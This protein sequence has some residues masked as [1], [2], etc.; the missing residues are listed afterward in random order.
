MANLEIIIDGDGHIFE[1]MVELR[2]HLP[3][4][5]NKTNVTQTLS[6]FPQIDHIHHGLGMNPPDTFGIGSDGVFRNPGV[7]GWHEFMEKAGIE[8]TVVYPTAA[9]GYGRMTDVDYAILACRAYNDWLAEAYVQN[10]SRFNGVA[11][12]PMQ[13][14]QAAVEE[15][16]RAVNDL[17]MVGAMLPST[18]LKSPLGD[19]EYW[20]VYAEAERLGCAMAIHGGAHQDLGMNTMNKVGPIHAI[21]HPT[22][23]I[24][25]FGSMI[26]NG[27]FDR[28]PTLK[29]GF[30]EAGVSWLLVAL[31][32]FSGSYHAVEPFPPSNGFPYRPHMDLHAGE[33]AA[34]YVKRLIKQ[35]NIFIGVEGDELT[36]AFAVKEVGPEPFIYSSDFPHEVNIHTVRDEIQELL[37]NEELTAEEKEGILHKNSQK[38]YG[39]TPVAAV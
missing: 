36:L 12:L 26:F 9:L 24:I 29:V 14:P 4:P 37:D 32:R 25:N 1:D 7:P 13:E 20:P 11:L 28:F 15:L 30:L 17:G 27:V 39:L 10:D 21:G 3:Y 34:D 6:V 38:F 31:E 5:L 19:P 16:R 35:G 22:G 23:I 2:K 18:G 33:E 8:S